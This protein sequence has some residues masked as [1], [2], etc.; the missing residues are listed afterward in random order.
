MKVAAVI[1]L[2]NPSGE[3]VKNIQSYASAIDQLFIVDNSTKPVKLIQDSFIGKPNVVYLHDGENKGIA[4]RLNEVI[5][6]AKDEYDWLLTM[7]Q[8]SRFSSQAF[9]NYIDCVGK[10]EQK[11]KVS[12]FGTNHAEKITTGDFCNSVSVKHLITSGS[13]LNLKVESKIGGFDENLFIDEVDFEYCLRSVLKGFQVIQFTH[14]FLEHNLGETVYRRS[15]KTTKLSSRV[16]HSPERLYYI[17]RN[18][19]YIRSKYQKTFPG[20]IKERKKILLNRI[21]NNLIYQKQRVTVLK[22]VMKG[23]WDYRKRRMGKLK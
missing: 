14:I 11:E 20:E 21:K 4:T 9:F 3:V 8:D 13:M 19:L 18:F 5:Q 12:M 17:T 22:Y 7:D 23:L 16:L 2:Y 1:I 10:F 6:L 15:F